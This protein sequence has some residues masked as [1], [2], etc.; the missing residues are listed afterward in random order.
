MPLRSLHVNTSASNC[1]APTPIIESMRTNP[2]LPRANPNKLFPCQQI[3]ARSRNGAIDAIDARDTGAIV[4]RYLNN[5]YQQR[6]FRRNAIIAA[7][8]PVIGWPYSGVN[9]HNAL[10]CRA[11]KRACKVALRTALPPPV[12]AK[13]RQQR[14]GYG[15]YLDLLSKS[16]IDTTEAQRLRDTRGRAPHE[17]V[18]PNWS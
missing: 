1:D 2:P 5:R 11:S 4:Y 13:I 7:F 14:H 8:I 9:T 18:A 10:R 16:N 12:F 3:A 15:D 17:A 6:S